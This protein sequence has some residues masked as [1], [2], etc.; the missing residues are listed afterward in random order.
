MEVFL[1]Q[2]SI[3]GCRVVDA[4]ASGKS[5]QLLHDTKDL[6]WKGIGTATDP[7]ATLA[8]AEVTAHLCHVLEDTQQQ[9]I[10]NNNNPRAVRNAQNQATYLN[11]FQVK[12]APQQQQE[13]ISIE[14]II[15]SCLGLEEEEDDDDDTEEEGEEE[16]A[17][18]IPSNVVWNEDTTTTDQTHSREWKER[19]E[20]VNV[21]LLKERILHNGRRPPQARGN[22][23]LSVISSVASADDGL[24]AEHHLSA[25]PSND[26]ADDG[27]VDETVNQTTRNVETPSS[28][29]NDDIANNDTNVTTERI[30]CEEDMEDINW[31]RLPDKNKTP[32]GDR[33][34]HDNHNRQTE[35]VPAVLRFYRTLDDLL[36]R[37]R[38]QRVAEQESSDEEFDFSD[39]R[40]SPSA[41]SAKDTR[42]FF[43]AKVKKLRDGQVERRRART[44]QRRKG[45]TNLREF[46]NLHQGYALVVL[47][48]FLWCTLVLVGFAGFGMYTF[49]QMQSKATSHVAQTVIS[50]PRAANPE[51][52]IRIIREVVHVREDGSVIDTASDDSAVSDQE[53]EMVTD[54]VASAFG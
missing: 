32:Q 46:A 10:S 30:I 5:K 17:G 20:R 18:S 21:E 42:K 43:N 13:A 14:E 1:D 12:D 34:V 53:L 40:A 50:Q 31:T 37:K 3:L 49:V 19:G 16:D 2:L 29:P 45:L 54:C 44:I 26:D 41:G 7:A 38:A 24:L 33:F 52:V 36:E 22:P 4:A 9:S 11:P 23:G 28:K 25:I 6:V 47:V 51:V 48:I 27:E 35:E 15:L 8:L 39:Q